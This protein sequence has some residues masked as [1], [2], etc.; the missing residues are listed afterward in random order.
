MKAAADQARP[1]S[2]KGRVIGN[3]I[4]I[5]GIPL[6]SD[7]PLFLAFIAAH[8]A[9]GLLCVFAGAV[10]MLS[11]K[12]R[13]RHPQTGTVYY[14]SLAIV[15]ATMSVL[16]ISRWDEDYRLFILG[17][18]SFLAATVGRMARRRL[19]LV[20]VQIHMAGMGIS[21]ILLITAF[22][23]DNGPNL[24]LWRELPPIAFWTLPVLIGTPIL[25][26][27]FFRHPLVR[28]QNSN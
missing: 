21:Y 22:Y 28:R 2:E 3:P 12:Q 9:A 15:A 18:L 27:A 20:W 10:A 5:A 26:N 19:W 7:S 13:G 25:L 8:V 24:P 11:R 14:W 23:V 16:A 1:I 6:P 4:T 17:V